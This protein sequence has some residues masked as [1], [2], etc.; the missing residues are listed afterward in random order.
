[1]AGS[2]GIWFW[3][4]IVWYGL[5]MVGYGARYLYT[6]SQKSLKDGAEWMNV[7]NHLRNQGTGFAPPP[8][9]YRVQEPI[10]GPNVVQGEVLDLKDARLSE[11]YVQPEV[12]DWMK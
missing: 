11:S 5:A 1:M 2:E 8:M 9:S 7:R 12:P 4:F 10:Q 3:F 6:R